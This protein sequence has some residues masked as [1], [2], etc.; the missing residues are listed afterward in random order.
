[1]HN[2][3]TSIVKSEIFLAITA[4]KVLLSKNGKEIQNRKRRKKNRQSCSVAK[5]GI[6]VNEK[7][8]KKNLKNTAKKMQDLD[9]T[10]SFLQIVK[11]KAKN[12][13]LPGRGV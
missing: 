11:Y 3:G 13:C 1:M 12:I 5:E 7:I 6:T 2:G 8:V 4:V 9:S 10:D